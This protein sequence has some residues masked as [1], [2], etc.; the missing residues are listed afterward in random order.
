LPASDDL[1]LLT[2]AAR[3][4]G[5]I[6]RAH[7]NREIRVWDKG[8]GA[9]PVTEADLKIDQMLGR[10]LRAARPDYGWLSEET[11]DNADRLEHERVFI[12]DPIDGTRAFASGKREFAHSIA[13]SER[14]RIVAA[15]VYLPLCDRMFSAAT[16]RPAR[17]NG[18]PISVTGAAL[19]GADILATRPNF[20]PE[21]WP[22]GVPEVV[23]HFRP[24]LAYRLC[25]VGEG[26]FDATLTLRPT[27]EWDVAA[28]SLIVECAGGVASDRTGHPPRFNNTFPRLNG[29]IAAGVKLHKALLARLT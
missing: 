14:G 3:A 20:D 10:E 8:A 16:G 2:D 28:G 23:R 7:W 22:G 26:R 19:E 18:R 1:D 25:L 15:A 12:V 6:A 4:S 27:W 11:E 17:L 29:M 24:S 9:G 21:F 13:V 5:D